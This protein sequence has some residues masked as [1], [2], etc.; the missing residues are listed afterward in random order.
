MKGI[1]ERIFSGLLIFS[2][3]ISLMPMGVMAEDS[4]INTRLDENE[5][6]GIINQSQ[7][8]DAGAELPEIST[9]S[10]HSGDYWYDDIAGGIKIVAYTGSGGNV[11]I[12][13]IIDGKIVLEIGAD[14]FK[15]KSTLTGVNLPNSVTV[16]GM[17]SFYN[18]PNLDSVFLGNGLSI[19]GNGSFW[20]AKALTSIIIPSS[21]TSIGYA[22]FANCDALTK[23]TILNSSLSFD[24]Q[25]F[26]TIPHLTIY[27]Y[28]GS[29]ADSYAYANTRP[30]VS[31][32][33]S[34]VD[35]YYSTHVQNV[36]WQ[37]SKKNGEISGT[38]GQGLRLEGIKILVDNSEVNVVIQYQTHVQNIGW[39][40]M[41]SDG[42]LSGTT[43]LSL[44]LE[45]IRIEL[46]GVDVG[47]HDVYYRVHAQ[48]YGWMD[49]ARNGE[50]AGTE[51]MG[52]RLEGIQIM[53][54]PKDSA[55]PGS[56]AHPFM[57]SFN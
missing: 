55:A 3:C 53:V 29:T 49:W 37:S 44:R 52:L 39:Q 31:L 16:L 26:G 35:S 19:I 38:V 20:G 24:G 9:D 27:G 8:L 15:E 7:I 36:G 5:E 11:D 22:A 50:S 18:C 14:A 40:P 4:N 33:S 21:V 32:P 43:G 51:G 25:V 10:V 47:K 23:I 30:F 12:P 56:T 57:S 48:N 41:V 1:R 46:D 42:A 2:V 34:Y 13:S 6:I 54:V 45:G 17:R 28:S